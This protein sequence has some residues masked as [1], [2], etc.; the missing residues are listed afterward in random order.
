M[1]SAVLT[2]LYI[3]G[4]VSMAVLA[5]N[6][7]QVL[8]QIEKEK[9][10]HRRERGVRDATIRLAKKGLIAFEERKG[11]RYMRLTPQGKRYIETL[12]GK[13]GQNLKRNKKW[14]GQWRVVI[15]DIPEKY[16]RK[17]DALRYALK[18]V[19]F[20]SIQKSVWVYPHECE[21]VVTLLKADQ[22]L[23]KSVL[24]MVVKHIEYDM[25]LRKH[26]GF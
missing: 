12:Y 13:G 18:R 22:Y 2:T 9:K 16:R 10:R 3:G 14:D 7:L 24:F 15:F 5:P 6:A 20:T 8:G 11:K 1:S 26:F 23:G 25:P 4:V 21:E 19:G 17:R